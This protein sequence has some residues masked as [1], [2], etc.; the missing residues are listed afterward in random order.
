[1]TLSRYGLGSLLE[2]QLDVAS[3]REA[4]V[5]AGAAIRRLHQARPT[6]GHHGEAE[7][8]DAPAHL[9][10]QRIARVV[11]VE[12]R[13]SEDRD[14]RSDKM[15]QP[16]SPNEVAQR[17]AEQQDLAQPRMRS[18]DEV[19]GRRGRGPAL[20]GPA[21][22]RSWIEHS[23]RPA[24]AVALE[25]L[26]AMETRRCGRPEFDLTRHETIA[27]PERRAG[28]LDAF[29]LGCALANT[30]FELLTRP[31]VGALSRGPRTDLALARATGKIRVGFRF[32][33]QFG[34]TVDTNLSVEHRPVHAKTRGRL[35]R[36]R[37]GPCDF[38]DSRRTRTRARPHTG[39]ARHVPTAGRRHRPLTGR[40]P[41]DPGRHARR[42]R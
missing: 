17:P 38:P 23:N 5:I 8:A 14:A 2:R 22:D 20:W 41:W 6:S 4:T 37:A 27:R 40:R 19:A 30:R 34:H 36:Q 15:Q 7:L 39:S 21:R 13:G 12:A 33:Q 18:L 24:L 10:R 35:R 11:F 1:M 29:E 26:P 42:P 31:E 16:E 32:G 25:Q 3:D 28:H 9:A